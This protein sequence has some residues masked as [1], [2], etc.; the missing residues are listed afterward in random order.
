MVTYGYLR[1][2]LHETYKIEKHNQVEI[3]DYFK[4]FSYKD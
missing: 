3:P 2:L 1:R 4:M